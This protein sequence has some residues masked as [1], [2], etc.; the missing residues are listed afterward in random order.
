MHNSQPRPRWR[1]F[2][3]A[4]HLVRVQGFCFALLQYNP[5]QAFTARFASSI[6]LYRQRHKTAHK[7]LQW[8]FLQFVPFYLH[9]Y[10]A[11]TSGY[12]T[13]CAILERIT[14]LQR[15]QRI[16]DTS[17]TPDAVQVSTAAYYNK[18]YKGAGVRLLWIHARRCNTSQTMPA[19]RG[20]RLHL[21]RVSPAAFDLAPGQPD[22]LHPAGQS[23]GKGTAGGAEPLA[24]TAVSLFGLSPDR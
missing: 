21:H 19:R 5:I 2:S 20:Q 14:A 16:P 22:T 15:L 10:Q 1:G 4:L 12:N 17:A 3:F 6:Q 7:A 13:A 18:V 11:D 9:K 24:A 8:L 23:S